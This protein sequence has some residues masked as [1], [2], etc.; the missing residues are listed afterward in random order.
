[1]RVQELTTE[2]AALKAQV[3]SLLA[4]ATTQGFSS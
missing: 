1:M 2:N 3:A 4:W